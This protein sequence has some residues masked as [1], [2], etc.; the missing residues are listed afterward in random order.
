MDTL[1]NI[2]KEVMITAV[3]GRFNFIDMSGSHA[4]VTLQ[5]ATLIELVEQL[6]TCVEAV[7]Q[8]TASPPCA[9]A[10]AESP[11]SA[12]CHGPRQVRGN[13]RT[14]WDTL[15]TA[16][17][18]VPP[19]QHT[20]I[21]HTLLHTNWQSTVDSECEPTVYQGVRQA[22]LEQVFQHGEGGQEG[23]GEEPEEESSNYGR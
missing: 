22:K 9:A 3:K 6:K 7:D 21:A 5:N 18:H 14:D 1:E 17:G 23:E 11:L 16:L 13:N 4:G 19:P 20:Q 2:I 10:A 8:T 12:G 15:A